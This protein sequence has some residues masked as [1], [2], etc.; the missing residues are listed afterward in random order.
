MVRD[1]RP[2]GEESRQ[3]VHPGPR[4][5]QLTSASRAEPPGRRQGPRCIPT[6]GPDSLGWPQAEIRPY[7]EIRLPREP[8]KPAASDPSGPLQKRTPL[9]QLV[10]MARS[11]R[12]PWSRSRGLLPRQR[13]RGSDR[14]EHLRRLHRPTVLPRAR[15]HASRE[16]RHLGRRHRA[17]ATADRPP[18]PPHGLTEPHPTELHGGTARGG[19]AA[20]PRGAGGWRTVLGRLAGHGDLTQDE[21]RAA[22]AEILEGARRP[23]RSPGSSSRCG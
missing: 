22:M 16:G 4:V 18:A 11:G 2:R 5:G 14:E 3:P 21:A 17:G 8:A 20:E 9:E 7:H 13:R 10:V 15:D 23:R 19:A 12:L 1:A 6:S